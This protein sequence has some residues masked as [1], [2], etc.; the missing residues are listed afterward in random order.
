MEVTSGKCMKITSK[1]K[2][3]ICT[4]YFLYQSIEN[5]DTSVL[6][7]FKALIPKYYSRQCLK[8]IHIAH[9]LSLKTLKKK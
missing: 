8:T 9:M 7:F 2:P 4:F 5:S 6:F 1:S 3:M